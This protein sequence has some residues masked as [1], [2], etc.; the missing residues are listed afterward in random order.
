MAWPTETKEERED[1]ESDRKTYESERNPPSFQASYSHHE[2]FT[3]T[4]DSLPP[5][6]N[7]FVT[8]KHDLHRGL[9]SRQIA[10]VHSLTAYHAN[11]NR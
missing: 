7:L 6:D 10:M 8:F 1:H 5:S 3:T 2:K 4:H 9:E 11:Y